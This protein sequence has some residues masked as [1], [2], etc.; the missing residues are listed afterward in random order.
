MH[1]YDPSG[2]EVG[3]YGPDGWMNKHGHKGKPDGIPDSVD[4]QCKGKAIEEARRARKIP[5]KGKADIK[6][7]KWRKFITSITPLWF[8]GFMPSPTRFIPQNGP[9]SEEM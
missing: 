2:K 6:G 7:N 4:N 1:V 3:V 5:D 9:Y 8:E